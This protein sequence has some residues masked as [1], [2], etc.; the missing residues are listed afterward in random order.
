MKE[1]LSSFGTKNETFETIYF[2]TEGFKLRLFNKGFLVDLLMRFVRMSDK[3][4]K[5]KTIEEIRQ[6]LTKIGFDGF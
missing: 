6:V 2:I 1:K 3:K 5:K 4:A